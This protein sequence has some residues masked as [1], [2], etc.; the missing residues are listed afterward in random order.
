MKKKILVVDD[1]E[2]ILDSIELIFETA[3]KGKYDVIAT[4]SGEEA[5]ELFKKEKPDLAIVDLMMPGVDGFQVCKYIKE[6]SIIPII[7]LTA[8]AD[9]ETMEMTRA[10]YKPELYMT[11]PFDK[12]ELINNAEKL[13]KK[14][15]KKELFVKRI[16]ADKIEAVLN[17][18]GAVIE[19][20]IALIDRNMNIAWINKS[21]EKK[22]FVFKNVV[23][24]KCYKIFNNLDSVDEN[25][26]TLKTFE[27][28]KVNKIVQKG[29]DGHDYRITA[30]PIK[31]DAGKVIYAVE[32][33][34]DITKLEKEVAA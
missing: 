34:E 3:V 23:G 10:W 21:L 16:P 22:G 24:H 2:A 11:K 32:F 4:P 13:L 31:D 26:P 29:A 6:N 33:S 12:K 1:D 5:L 15:E 28:G 17:G 18:I 27:N 9:K 19:Q 8:R 20:G 25:D 7:I 14:A 30:I